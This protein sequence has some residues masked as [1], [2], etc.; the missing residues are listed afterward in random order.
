MPQLNDIAKIDKQLTA[1]Q[2]QENEFEEI[3]QVSEEPDLSRFGTVSSMMF[4]P[5]KRLDSIQPIHKNPIDQKQKRFD[6]FTKREKFIYQ[7]NYGRKIMNSPL[8]YTPR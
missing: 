1:L 3:V 7:R 4:T 8:N 2:K 6:S 5:K